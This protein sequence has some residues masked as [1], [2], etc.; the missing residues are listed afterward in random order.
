M[1]GQ[2]RLFVEAG[3]RMSPIRS[4]PFDQPV[5]GLPGDQAVEKGALVCLGADGGADLANA[6]DPV[7]VDVDS[8]ERRIAVVC[9][10]VDDLIVAAVDPCAVP[11]LGR[12]ALVRAGDYRRPY[13]AVAGVITTGLYASR[14]WMGPMLW[15][16]SAEHRTRRGCVSGADRVQRGFQ[17]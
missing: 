12:M 10:F 2:L 16:Q 3:C 4:G 1:R 8:G 14:R 6:A 5:H 7:V 13:A 9:G 17:G 15:H 11:G